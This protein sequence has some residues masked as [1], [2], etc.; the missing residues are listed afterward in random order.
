MKTVDHMIAL[1]MNSQGTLAAASSQSS[2]F[3]NE[4]EAY[5][6]TSPSETCLSASWLC[7]MKIK[8]DC[9]VMQIFWNSGRC[10]RSLNWVRIKTHWV[11]LDNIPLSI[12]W[13][14]FRHNIACF[15]SFWSPPNLQRFRFLKFIAK[16]F[17]FP[18]FMAYTI[19]HR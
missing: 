16:L 1:T 18:R 11:G 17:A 12:S 13:L 9:H 8:S 15:I 14:V 5:M 2:Y 6:L 10:R 7:T 19:Y 3:D 4:V